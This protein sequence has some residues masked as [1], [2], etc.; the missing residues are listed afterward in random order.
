M[1][2]FKRTF[3]GSVVGLALAAGASVTSAQAGI[4]LWEHTNWSGQRWA[5][6]YSVSSVGPLAGKVSSLE[7]TAGDRYRLYDQYGYTGHST[8]QSR[9]YQDLRLIGWN[10]RIRSLK[11]L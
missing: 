1:K 5:T 10:D 6:D 11:I 3:I 4:V 7:R 8:D 2:V 9:D